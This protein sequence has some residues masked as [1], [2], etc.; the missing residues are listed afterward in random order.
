[1]WEKVC[2]PTILYRAKLYKHGEITS[3]RAS[4]INK[5]WESHMILALLK[6][7]RESNTGSNQKALE[8][9]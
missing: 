6:T 3:L 2:Q 7:I 9:N 4:Q 1:M 5:S 8:S